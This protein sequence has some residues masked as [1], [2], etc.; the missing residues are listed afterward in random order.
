MGTTEDTRS[1][2]A[3]LAA[4]RDDPGAFRALYDRHAERVR[5]YHLRR[6]GDAQAALDLT[7]ETFAQ[8][9]LG[10]GRFHD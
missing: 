1:D 6:S 4:A 9:W 10:R 2:A 5:G 7:A 3:L 8:A